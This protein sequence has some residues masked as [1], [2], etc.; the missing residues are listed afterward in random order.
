[1]LQCVHGRKI[2]F[3]N[4]TFDATHWLHCLICRLVVFGNTHKNMYVRVQQ[5]KYACELTS[6]CVC[7]IASFCKLVNLQPSK[8]SRKRTDDVSTTMGR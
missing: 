5:N 3:I 6:V 1:M 2:K 4:V 7:V 8:S